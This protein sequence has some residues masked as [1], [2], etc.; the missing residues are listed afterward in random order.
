MNV[1]DCVI[2]FFTTNLLNQLNVIVDIAL[3]YLP[4]LTFVTQQD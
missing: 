2:V 3:A 4:I 1:Q